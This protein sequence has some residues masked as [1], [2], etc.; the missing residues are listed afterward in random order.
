MAMASL[1]RTIQE[2]WRN[3]VPAATVDWDL[4]TL[5]TG[6]QLATRAG[7]GAG[8]T[9]AIAQFI[10]LDFPLYAALAAIIATD[11]TPPQTRQLGSRRLLATVLGA[12]CGVLLAIVLAPSAWSIGLSV[13]MAM[14][15]CEVMKARD[16]ARVAAYLCSIIVFYHGEDPLQFSLH[17]FIETVLGVSI[18]WMI[19]FVP[20]LIRMEQE[21]LPLEPTGSSCEPHD[22]APLQQAE[23]GRTQGPR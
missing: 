14:L 1:R 5:T 20:K 8:L 21:D 17:R 11:L 9:L 6:T 23:P 10:G 2:R 12:L 13:L 7:V 4:R 19:S 3:A 16:G 18:A 15:V 22:R